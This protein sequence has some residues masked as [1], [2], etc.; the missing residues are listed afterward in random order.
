MEAPASSSSARPRVIIDDEEELRNPNEAH[1]SSFRP[2][3]TAAD[4]RNDQGNR[5]QE[6]R[7][8]MESEVRLVESE[9]GS[10]VNYPLMTKS[11]PFW[12]TSLF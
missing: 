5:T 9:L 1:D 6:E 10:I 8:E 12:L 2:P 11:L 7:S 4:E 3:P